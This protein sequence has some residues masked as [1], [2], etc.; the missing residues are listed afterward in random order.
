MLLVRD[1][2]ESELQLLPAVAAQRVNTSPVR[3]SECTRTRTFSLPATSPRMSATWSL[4]VRTSLNATAVNS[5]NLVGRRTA[6]TRSTSF[7]VRR[8]YSIRSAIVTIFRP[9]SR[10]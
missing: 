5:P 3:H 8:R 4:S 1:L 7:S 6:I 10:Q 2:L 9:C